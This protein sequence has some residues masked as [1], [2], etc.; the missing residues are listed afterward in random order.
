MECLYYVELIV[1]DTLT[2]LGQFQ[3]NS[4]VRL[5]RWYVKGNQV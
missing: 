4:L 3:E 1:P 2:I 5:L